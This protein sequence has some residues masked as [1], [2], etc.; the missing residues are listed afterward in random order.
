MLCACTCLGIP[1][2]TLTAE[3]KKALEAMVE[4][5]VATKL[6]SPRLTPE[7]AE[8]VQ[9]AMFLLFGEVGMPKLKAFV[10]II[11]YY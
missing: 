10:S 1:A 4:E 8:K 9:K 3:D 6:H 11:Q 7:Q 5:M 2:V